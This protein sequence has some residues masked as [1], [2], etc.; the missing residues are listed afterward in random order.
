M[1]EIDLCLQWPVLFADC[2][3][4]RSASFASDVYDHGLLASKPG[5]YSMRISWVYTGASEF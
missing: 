2:R 1:W 4:W 3:S 5:G